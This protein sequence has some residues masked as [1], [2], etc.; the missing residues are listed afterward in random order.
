MFK[1]MLVRVCRY[2]D[3]NDLKCHLNSTARF[4]KLKYKMVSMYII[5]G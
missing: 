5:C 1:T 3:L 2:F 4:G